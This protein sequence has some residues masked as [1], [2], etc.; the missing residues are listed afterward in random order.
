MQILGRI[1]K[2]IVI[3]LILVGLLILAGF[4]LFKN[5]YAFITSDVPNGVTYAGIDKSEYNIQG[6]LED[7]TDPKKTYQNETYDLR[8]LEESRRVHTGNPNPFSGTL[9][10]DNDTDLLTERVDIKNEANPSDDEM[11]FSAS[12]DAVYVP[13][14]PTSGDAN[15]LTDEEKAK[16]SDVA[17]QPAA[18]EGKK[19]LE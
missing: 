10:D 14:A 4:F 5:Q 19:E 17:E 11:Y 1:A 16:A 13:K 8:Y 9:D 18:E 3:A 6:D 7:Q 15:T 12:G 2:E